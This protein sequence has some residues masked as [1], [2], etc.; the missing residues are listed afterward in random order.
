[1]GAVGNHVAA[2]EEDE[3]GHEVVDDEEDIAG[4][5]DEVVDEVDE[6]VGDAELEDRVVEGRVRGGVGGAVPRRGGA[7]GGDR[8]GNSCRSAVGEGGE[9]AGGEGAAPR[10]PAAE[11]EEVAEEVD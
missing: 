9:A 8:S 5:E 3:E 11:E 10:A 7:T 4:E 6:E 2:G 1:M